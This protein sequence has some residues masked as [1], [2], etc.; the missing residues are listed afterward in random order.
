[1]YKS[2]KIYKEV[3][4]KGILIPDH[5]PHMTIDISWAYMG[6]AY[7][8]GYISALLQVVNE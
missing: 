3:G 7:A 1:M 8:V 4:F 2:I 6:R 5:V